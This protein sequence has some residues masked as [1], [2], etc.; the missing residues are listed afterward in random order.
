MKI[1]FSALAAGEQRQGLV[2]AKGRD[3]AQPHAGSGRHGL[4][5]RP[6]TAKRRSNGSGR[7]IR[8]AVGLGQPIDEG[9]FRRERRTVAGRSWRR[10]SATGRLMGFGCLEITRRGWRQ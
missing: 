6:L 2:I 5:P 9:L 3:H 8:R 1:G 4:P 10:K 7:P